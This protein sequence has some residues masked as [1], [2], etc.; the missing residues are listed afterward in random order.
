MGSVAVQALDILDWKMNGVQIWGAYHGTVCLVI[1]C[2]I[3]NLCLSGTFLT[4][5]TMAS[6][7][8]LLLLQ[9][10]TVRNLAWEI[11]LAK[12][13]CFNMTA[14]MELA[15]PVCFYHRHYYFLNLR[16]LQIVLWHFSKYKVP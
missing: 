9:M 11:A 3:I 2:A 8:W 10:W 6:S 1:I 5:V 4:S 14:M 15:A 7:H 13:H 16:V 12:L